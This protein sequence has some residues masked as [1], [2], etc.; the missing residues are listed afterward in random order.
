MFFFLN[1]YFNI[2]FTDS[3]IFFL[4]ITGLIFLD[5]PNI[6]RPKKKKMIFQ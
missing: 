3:R 2:T 1:F 4:Q 6:G 5:K